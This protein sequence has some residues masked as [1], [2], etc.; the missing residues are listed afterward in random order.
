[1][2]LLVASDFREA[3]RTSL[4]NRA[5]PSASAGVRRSRDGQAFLLQRDAR[6]QHPWFTTAAWDGE[7]WV[8]TV[9]PGLVN[10]IDPLVPSGVVAGRETRVE[11][12][13]LLDSPEIPLVSVRAPG[14]TGD[15]IP[16]FFLDL[17]VR[18]PKSNIQVSDLGGVTIL[19]ELDAN[20]LPP[21]QLRAADLYL[22][23]ARPTYESTLTIS[24]ATGISG[25]VADYSVGYNLDNVE[26]NGRR[27]RLLQAG[28]F[29]APYKATLI[30]RLLG[31]YQD[32]GED[33]LLVS[34]VYFVS[35][36][37]FEGELDASWTPYVSHSIFWNVMHGTVNQPPRDPAQRITLFTGLAGGWG[38]VII[39]QSLAPINDLADQIL[40]AVTNVTP[41][42]RF[43]TV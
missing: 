14:G 37:D 20:P 8:A 35:P 23:V 26:R 34:T 40:N 41:E 19:D 12:V 13:S 1:M 25:Q 6:Y 27:A 17:G 16:Q 33:R 29:P 7:R 24:D 5:M 3:V 28:K 43:W 38:D 31:N 4:E 9:R 39:N 21:R 36:P 18:K 42:G 15:L 32:E 11:G 2:N 30:D 22:A 10:G